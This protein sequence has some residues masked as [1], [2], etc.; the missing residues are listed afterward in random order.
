MKVARLVS[1]GAMSFSTIEKPAPGPGDVLVKVSAAGICGSDRHMFKGEFPTSIPVTLGHEFS[2]VVEAVGRD[3]T[4][5]SGGELVTVDPNIACGICTAC[6][7]A[8]PNLCAR[9]TAIGVTRDGGFADYA[10]VP[11]GQAFVLPPGLD[12]VHGAFSEPLACC[13]HAIDKAAIRAGDSVA[14]LGGG[15][16]GLLMVQLAKLEGAGTVMLITRQASRRQMALELG[17]THAYDPSATDTVTAVRD[18]SG[19]GADVVIECAGVPETFRTGIA[20]TRRG[21]RFVLFGVTPAGLEVPVT[22]FDLLVNEVSIRPAYLNPFTHGR[23]VALV[24]SGVLELDRLVT[25]IIGLDAVGDVV[26]AAPE[27]GEIKVIVRP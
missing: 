15:V 14:I 13:L 7:D 26:A 19:G 3:V 4:R 17:A 27:A 18:V 16:I 21:G 24:A 9:L 10:V 2:G 23:A 20:M 6:R 5:F 25:R 12:P 8:K 11:E 22:P 1:V